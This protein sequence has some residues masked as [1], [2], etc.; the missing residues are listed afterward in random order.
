ML[1]ISKKIK[2]YTLNALDGEIG[3]VKEFFFDDRFWTIRYLVVATGGW[4][5]EKRVLISPYF[6]SNVDHSSELIDVNLTQEEIKNS[7]EWDS[8]KPV[9]RHYETSYY[10]YYGAP[11]YWAGPHMW[12]AYPVFSRD[13]EKWRTSEKTDESWDPNLRST[14]DVSGHNIQATDDTIGHVEDFIID[15]EDWAIRYIV[16]DTK[17]WLPGKNVLVSPE[18]IDRIS[19]PETKVFVNL[20]R[21]LIKKAPEYKSDMNITR[22]YESS[23]YRHYQRQGY[24]VGDPMMKEYTR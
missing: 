22:D 9:S 4:F 13:R 15:D 3:D 14:K 6:L 20:S 8:D 21:D 12:G 23:L 16:V 18:W 17:N 11:M 5:N 19:W 10:G 2:G 1:T 7:P 24:W